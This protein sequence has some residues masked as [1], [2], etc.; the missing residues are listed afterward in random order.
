MAVYFATKAYVL[1]FT[2][3]LHHELRGTGVTA[4]AHCPGATATE[5]ARVAGVEGRPLFAGGLVASS[6]AVA[7]HAYRAMQRGRPVA[8][9][10]LLNKLGAFSTRFAPRRLTAAISA[11]LTRPR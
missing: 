2:A 10:G 1:S 11:R 9:H 6:E 5:F 8:V 7:R 4:T 3:A